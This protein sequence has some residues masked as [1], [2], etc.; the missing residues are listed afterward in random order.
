MKF[1]TKINVYFFLLTIYFKTT[2]CESEWIDP[3]N[4]DFVANERLKEPETTTNNLSG[5]CPASSSGAMLY[6]KR[7][8]NL[9]LSSVV[10][11]EISGNY[12]GKLVINLQMDDFNVLKEFSNGEID[13]PLMLKKINDIITNTLEMTFVDQIELAFI[14]WTEIFYNIVKSQTTWFVLITL[15]VIFVVYRLLNA[16][17]SAKEVFCYVAL[18]G[19][20]FD[21]CITWKRILQEH[22]INQ[23][24]DSLQYKNIPSDCFPKDM[25]GWQV[26]MSYFK[27]TTD[28]R[29][30]Y[31]NMMYDFIWEVGPL[32]VIA[33]QTRV[34]IQIFGNIGVAISQMVSGFMTNFP[35]P[36]NLILLIPLLLFVLTF[37]C[38]I[39]T[40]FT[41]TQIYIN[42]MYIIQFTLKKTPTPTVVYREEIQEILAPEKE[43]KTIKIAPKN[44]ESKKSVETIKLEDVANESDEKTVRLVE[45]P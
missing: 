22:E 42:L 19:Y 31:K 44:K 17:F 35:F 29:Q 16:K 23:Y 34:F 39:F 18:L 24:A 12:K 1:L 30:Y 32:D 10:H 4:I 8:I 45:E 11:D 9:L 13:E 25:N 2:L 15:S 43:S 27:T 20:V 26:F 40:Y 6:Y 14:N 21:F 33:H 3:F 37:M 28:C 36:L 5:A 41:N 7:T 38:I